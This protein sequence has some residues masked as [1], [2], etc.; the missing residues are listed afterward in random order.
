M[1]QTHFHTAPHKQ[2]HN[3][4]GPQPDGALLATAQR[5]FNCDVVLWE[6]TGGGGRNGNA[7]G[8]ATTGR[9]RA[10]Q[11]SRFQE[12]DVAVAALAFSCDGRLLATAGC[13]E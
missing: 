3:P 12:H 1:R 2:T 8:N 4:P 10:R 11:R 6:L 13:E 9:G 7:T 5:G